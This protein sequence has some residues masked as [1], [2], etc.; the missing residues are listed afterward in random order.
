MHALG[1]LGFWDAG[2]ECVKLVWC[3]LLGLDSG[4]I[5]YI[6][7]DILEEDFVAWSDALIGIAIIIS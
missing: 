7:G 6:D 2:E 5:L 1:F 4:V 3:E